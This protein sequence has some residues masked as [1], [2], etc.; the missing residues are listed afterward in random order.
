MKALK[1]REISFEAAGRTDQDQVVN[2]RRGFDDGDLELPSLTRIHSL[3]NGA[4]RRESGQCVRGFR[5]DMKSVPLGEQGL[6][7]RL[8]ALT[9]SLL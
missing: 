5:Q 4:Q 9:I 3:R 2:A 7:H 1:N 8:Q 6:R